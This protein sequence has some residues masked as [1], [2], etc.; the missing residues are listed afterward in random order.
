M[1]AIKAFHRR[2][3]GSGI[4]L[5]AGVV[6][7]VTE[8]GAA[9]A[10]QDI[11]AQR[12]HVTKLRTRG[13]FQRIRHHG[14]IFL[15]FR[16]GGDVR[17]PSHGAKAQVSAVKADRRPRRR[18]RIDIHDCLRPHHIQ[19]HQVDQRG[20][21][22]ERLGLGFRQ[23]V[24]C[25]RR[26]SQCLNRER[27]IGGAPIGKGSHAPSLSVREWRARPASRPR[28]CWDRPRNGRCCRSYVRGC[29]RRCRRGL[30]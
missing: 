24:A 2:A 29:S 1:G 19:L 10:L 3:A 4:A 17:H 16:V 14:I 26:R 9:R 28:R 23:R 5:V 25:R 7:D 27:G 6:A 15:D 30:P 20:A 21:A 11:A 8:I 18:K 13:K 12:R 22:G